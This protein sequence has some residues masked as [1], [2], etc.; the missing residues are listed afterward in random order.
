MA[1]TYDELPQEAQD[2]FDEAMDDFSDSATEAIKEKYTRGVQRALEN[3]DYR[4][5]LAERFNMDV[6]D[7]SGV[8]SL[9]EDGID[10]TDADD[11]E[12]ALEREGVS[13]K[14]RDELV[15]GL[16]QEDE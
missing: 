1:M 6:S 12:A 10:D 16:T 15:V 9:W 8:N 3:D 7:F 5:G 11:W 4:E 14:F 13:Q 2:A